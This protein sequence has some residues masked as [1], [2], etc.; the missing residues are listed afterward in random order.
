MV[1]VGHEAEVAGGFAVG[2]QQPVQ[3]GASAKPCDYVAR[4]AMRRAVEFGIL[5]PVEEEATIALR[6]LC[7]ELPRFIKP[8]KLLQRGDSISECCGV[9]RPQPAKLLPN[10]DGAL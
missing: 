10:G 8:P 5:P 6:N 9:M 3:V 2:N 1:F 7:K 4:K